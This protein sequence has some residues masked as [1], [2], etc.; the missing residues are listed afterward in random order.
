MRPDWNLEA[1]DFQYGPHRYPTR[2]RNQQRI[3]AHYDRFTGEGTESRYQEIAM[4]WNRWKRPDNER[5]LNSLRT[6]T[7]LVTA[8][9]IGDLATVRLLVPDTVAAMRGAPLRLNRTRVTLEMY[10]MGEGMLIGYDSQAFW[11]DLDPRLYG[12]FRSTGAGYMG[13]DISS[14]NDEHPEL[15][16]HTALTAASM[17]G[18]VDIIDHLV[19]VSP[20]LPHMQPPEYRKYRTTNS[21][22]SPLH[23][24]VL[25]GHWKSLRQLIRH[26]SPSTREILNPLFVSNCSNFTPCELGL[27]LCQTKPPLAVSDRHNIYMCMLLLVCYGDNPD[28]YKVVTLH[29]ALSEIDEAVRG[30]INLATEKRKTYDIFEYTNIARIENRS[31]QISSRLPLT[32]P[33]EICNIIAGYDVVLVPDSD[34]N[35]PVAHDF[36][37]TFF[38]AMVKIMNTRIDDLMSERSTLRD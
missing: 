12:R 8:C 10:P 4:E 14:I 25:H 9:A 31:A 22:D 38:K 6:N 26:A 29:S 34:L 21:G 24:A 2:H 28:Y 33:V 5:R 32:V 35:E 30:V 17:N 27:S 15:I 20:V 19:S 13:W 18:H 36:V 37:D 7:K 11:Y 23:L 3:R 16:G 1:A